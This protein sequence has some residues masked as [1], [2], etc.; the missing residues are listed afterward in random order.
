MG[1]LCRC[2]SPPG[3]TSDV[4]NRKRPT[5]V[6]SLAAHHEFSSG[7]ARVE[8]VY[9]VDGGWALG[10]GSVG[11]VRVVARRSDGQRVAMKSVRLDK[12]SGE[13]LE[14][15]RREIRIQKGLAHP[16]IVRLLESYEDSEAH[17]MHLIMELC[18]GGN[19][20]SRISSFSNEAG[21]VAVV[22]KILRAI[23][24]LHSHGVVHRDINL[25]N[26]VYESA[27]GD[28]ELKMIDFGLA[29][30]VRPGADDMFERLGTLTYMAPELL[31]HLTREQAYD[32][33]VGTSDAEPWSS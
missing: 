8:E 18:T 29:C 3:Y 30:E 5:V 22:E 24:Y 31:D 7:G 20:V 9:D 11:V 2:F 23:I 27:A 14:M 15:L 4:S 16:N 10:S 28:A 1:T 12:L 13:G 32:S 6:A 21:A 17:Q 26:F 19:L 25:D 33:S